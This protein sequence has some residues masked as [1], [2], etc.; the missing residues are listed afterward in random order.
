VG[1]D[2]EIIC[3]DD[4]SRDRTWELLKTQNQK[5]SPALPFI[6]RNFGHQTAVSAGLYHATG[7]PSSSLTPICRTAGGNHADA[8]RNGAR[9]MTWSSPCGKNQRSLV[10]RVLAWGFYRLLA[11]LTPFPIRP[12]PAIL[13]ARQ[14][15]CRR[16][17]RTAGTQPL[18][19]R[20]ADVVWVQTNCIEFERGSAPPGCRNTPFKNPQ[21]G[22]GTACSPSRPC[23]CGWRLIFGLWVSGFRIS[24]C[25][26]HA[27]CRNFSPRNLP[28][29]TR[30]G[31]RFP[32]DCDFDPV[33]SGRP[34]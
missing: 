11:K 14:K 8:L 28:N 34:V 30:A 32:D 6:R 17:E 9:D 25:G 3:V 7:M 10:K 21:A 33:S 18:P 5:D 26:I 24:R 31:G 19:A 4:G 29:R 1:A 13:P 27:A 15:S 12:K 20:L 22:D 23:R 2:Y 16:D